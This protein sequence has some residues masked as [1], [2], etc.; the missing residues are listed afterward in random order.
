MVE[1]R[2]MEDMADQ[3]YGDEGY[4]P[5]LQDTDIL[6]RPELFYEGVYDYR[7][8]SSH[9]FLRSVGHVAMSSK[10]GYG[11]VK[12]YSLL[13]QMTSWNLSTSSVEYVN[14]L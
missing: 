9:S 10:N 3:Y 8:V 11:S 14:V 7:L 1:T 4:D 5:Y 13:D 12:G 2:Q 6:D